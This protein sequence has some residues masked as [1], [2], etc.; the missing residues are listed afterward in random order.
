MSREFIL[1]IKKK[2][3]REYRSHTTPWTKDLQLQQPT[4][5][6]R[7]SQSSTT[8]LQLQIFQAQSPKNQNYNR[9]SLTCPSIA[10]KRD[11]WIEIFSSYTITNIWAISFT[12]TLQTVWLINYASSK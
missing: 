8:G 4:E 1:S 2:R 12:E 7:K 11:E 6:V 10:A 5:F 9:A 3:N